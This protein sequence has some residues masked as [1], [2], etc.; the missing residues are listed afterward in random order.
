[1]SKLEKYPVTSSEDYFVNGFVSHGKSVILK[2]VLFEKMSIGNVYNLALG[3]V[4]PITD[5]P[6][7]FVKARNGDLVKVF[8][9]IA[10]IITKFT[11]MHPNFVVYIK[12]NT[13]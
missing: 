12:G 1:M 7:Y 11:E 9:T 6:D 13:S 3:D 5:E 10:G 4:N 8:A 2:E